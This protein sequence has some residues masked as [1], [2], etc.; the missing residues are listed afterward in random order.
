[1]GHLC[2]KTHT[3]R[4]PVRCHPP[5]SRLTLGSRSRKV[6]PCCPGSL[7]PEVRGNGE[8]IHNRHSTYRHSRSTLSIW[9]RPARVL[10]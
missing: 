3:A 4:M 10:A 7:A 5:A 9:V 1:M 2:P 8:Q 6:W